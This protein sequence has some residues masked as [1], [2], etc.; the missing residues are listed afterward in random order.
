MFIDGLL[1]FLGLYGR[2]VLSDSVAEVTCFPNV[3]LRAN[4]PTYAID[5]V[6]CA[7]RHVAKYFVDTTFNRAF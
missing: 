3:L 7:A 5:A 6:V 4:L 2:A 1:D